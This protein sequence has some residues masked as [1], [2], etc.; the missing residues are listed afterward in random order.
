MNKPLKSLAQ[1]LL[2]HIETATPPFCG[3]G[4]TALVVAVLPLTFIYNLL[5]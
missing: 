4:E 2:H 5:D 1:E 3:R